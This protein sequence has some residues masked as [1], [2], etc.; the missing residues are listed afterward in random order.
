M[1]TQNEGRF[2]IFALIAAAITAGVLIAK[3]KNS[4]ND[5]QQ[6]DEEY[7]RVGKNAEKLFRQGNYVSAVMEISKLLAKVIRD[8]SGIRKKDGTALIDAA[9]NPNSGVLKFTVHANHDNIQTHE[10]YYFLCK[11]VFLA[12]RN[13]VAHANI[14]LTKKQAT[15]Q[16]QIISYLIEHVIHHTTPI[17]REE[18]G[19]GR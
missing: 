10:G 13:P 6:T 12:F 17:N 7:D 18:G 14:Q 5:K 4:E 8:K 16:I 3:N 11:G 19:G 2:W 15:A 1:S 9:L